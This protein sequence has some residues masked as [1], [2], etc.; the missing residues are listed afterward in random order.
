MGRVVNAEGDCKGSRLEL[1]SAPPSLQQWQPLIAAKGYVAGV[2]GDKNGAGSALKLLEETAKTRFVTSYG[3]ALV[4][5]GLGDR[6][7]TLLWLRKAVDR[8]EDRNVRHCTRTPPPG[9]TLSGAQL[10]QRP[11]TAGQP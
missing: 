8:K 4:E 9:M 11:Q 2:C 10:T 5:A 6:V 1:A 3:I 7:A